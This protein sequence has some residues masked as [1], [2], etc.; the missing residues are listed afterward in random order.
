M[1]LRKSGMWNAFDEEV[2]E[3]AEATCVFLGLAKE[4]A[5]IID[6]MAVAGG[7]PELHF[8]H[9]QPALLCAPLEVIQVVIKM[10]AVPLCTCAVYSMDC[11]PHA[12][13]FGV[14]V[15]WCRRWLLFSRLPFCPV[16]ITAVKQ[17]SLLCNS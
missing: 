9:Q 11:E 5:Q 8:C 1:G 7:L 12:G 2:H 4:L 14:C 6:E 16:T 10:E 15:I 17:P 13:S 3:L